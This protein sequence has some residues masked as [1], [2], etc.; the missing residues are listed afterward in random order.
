MA[1]DNKVL[2][3]TLIAGED[4]SESQYHFVSIDSDGLAVLT[5]DEEVAVGV[6]Q[7]DPGEGEAAA[8]RVYGLTKLVAGGSIAA[9][10]IV[11]SFGGKGLVQGTGIGNGIALTGAEEDGIFTLLISRGL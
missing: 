2:D 5:T 7:N 10:D 9:G 6:L 1:Y 8:V 11:E 3:I 4:L